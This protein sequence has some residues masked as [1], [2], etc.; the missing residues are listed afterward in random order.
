MLDQEYWFSAFAWSIFDYANYMYI[1]DSDAHDF[2]DQ[3]AYVTPSNQITNLEQL[4]YYSDLQL[5]GWYGTYS[6]SITDMF[7]SVAL[8]LTVLLAR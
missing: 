6:E 5:W 4:R 1:H 7:D 2:L 8:L 3:K